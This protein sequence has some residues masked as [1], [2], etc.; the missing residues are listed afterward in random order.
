MLAGGREKEE[1]GGEGCPGMKASAMMLHRGKDDV[2][3]RYYS[4]LTDIFRPFH[5]L[6]LDK[7]WGQV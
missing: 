5:I 6:K 1:G 3:I 2:K 7:Q 4:F